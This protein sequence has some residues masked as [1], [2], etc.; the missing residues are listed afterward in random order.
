M[1]PLLKAMQVYRITL[2]SP[3]DLTIKFCFVEKFSKIIFKQ[4]II[5]GLMFFMCLKVFQNNF[6]DVLQH[7]NFL[8]LAFVSNIYYAYIF[9]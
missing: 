2:L 4:L 6:F 9:C 3:K 1:F 5:S 7:L 8:S